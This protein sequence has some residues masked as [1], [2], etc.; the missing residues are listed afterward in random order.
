MYHFEIDVVEVVVVMVEVVELNVLFERYYCY[1]VLLNDY[2]LLML[3]IGL[4]YY[5]FK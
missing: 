4:D 5:L 3:L 1:L 2:D